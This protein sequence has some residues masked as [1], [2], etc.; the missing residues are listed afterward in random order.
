MLQEMRRA[1]DE[2]AQASGGDG[3]LLSVA[4]SIM[5]HVGMLPR[6]LPAFRTRY[7][8]VTLQIS[9]GLFNHVEPALR[10]GTLDFYL[11]TAPPVAPAPGLSCEW[12][13]ANPR[14]VFARKGHPLAN[15]TSLPR[16][17]RRRMGHHA[18]RLRLRAGLRRRL[19]APPPER[20]RVS[21]CGRLPRCR[22]WSR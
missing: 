13:F 7:P 17:G 18:R 9:E 1:R 14:A 6:A 5:P 20:P 3:G 16:T 19:Y 11:G 22:S 8:G 12:L 2:I 4:L 15:A 21:R 10:N